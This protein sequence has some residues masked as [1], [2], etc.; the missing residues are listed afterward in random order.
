MTIEAWLSIDEK[1]KPK[2]MR[3]WISRSKNLFQDVQIRVYNKVK[4]IDSFYCN[5]CGVMPDKAF[6]TDNPNDEMECLKC[7]KEHHSADEF[8][9]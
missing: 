1:F 4:D 2:T 6:G 9:T 7:F 3:V 5:S 8:L